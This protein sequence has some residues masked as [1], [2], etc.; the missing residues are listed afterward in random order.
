MFT[1]RGIRRVE[2]N[3]TF[4][5]HLIFESVHMSHLDMAEPIDVKICDTVL[6][7]LPNGG[8]KMG[9]CPCGEIVYY[10]AYRGY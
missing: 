8:G 4:V 2:P 5:R 3:V 6:H 9:L 1:N 10:S 7:W